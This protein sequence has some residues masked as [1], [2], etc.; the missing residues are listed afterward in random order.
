MGLFKLI[1]TV[2]EIGSCMDWLTPAMSLLTT[3]RQDRIA[4]PKVNINEAEWRLKKAG[5]RIKNRQIIHGQFVF[6]V[7]TGRGDEA[8]RVLGIE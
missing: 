6:D 5:I 4:V 1:D 7:E 3:D 2:L 8:A